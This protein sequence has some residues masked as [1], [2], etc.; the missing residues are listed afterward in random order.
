MARR[1]E[2]RTRGGGETVTCM[3]R[4]SCVKRGAVY[5]TRPFAGG[6]LTSDMTGVRV[7]FCPREAGAWQQ[8]APTRRPSRDVPKTSAFAKALVGTFLRATRRFPATKCTDT[9][10]RRWA[11]RLTAESPFRPGLESTLGMR[12]WTPPTVNIERAFPT[13]LVCAQ[14]FCRQRDASKVRECHR[15][16]FVKLNRSK[17]SG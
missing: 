1:A 5:L 17:E 13:W 4:M 15:S 10:L 3:F 2:C 8:R 12:T 11:A 14:R 16:V 7:W 9:S 6:D